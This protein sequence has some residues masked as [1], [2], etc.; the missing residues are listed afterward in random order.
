M[1][2]VTSDEMEMSKVPIIRPRIMLIGVGHV[3]DIREKIRGVIVDER[4]QTVALELDSARFYSL[5]NRDKGRGEG[6]LIYQLLARFQSELAKEYGTEVGSEMIAAA[7][8]AKEVGANI[9]LIDMD[10]MKMFRGLR[11]AM[12]LKEKVL[13]AVGTV[14]SLFARKST[15]EKELERYQKDEERFIAE[16]K[17]S[18]PTVMRVLI[19]ERNRYM[20]ERLKEISATSQN[21]IAIVGDGHISGMQTLVSDFADVDIIRLNELQGYSPKL[22]NKEISFSFTIG[23]R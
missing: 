2:S 23:N 5:L 18:Y 22:D 10:S 3:F 19:D 8:A 20:A 21:T 4:P 12:S 7:N 13:L 15:V 16:V 14:L 1:N 17:K 11:Q 9:A 6:P